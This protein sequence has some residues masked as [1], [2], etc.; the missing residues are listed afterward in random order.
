M[1]TK[2]EERAALEKIV[3]IIGGLGVDSYIGAAIDK[4]VLDIAEDNITNDWLITTTS[5][6]ESAR[7][8]AEDFKASYW[9]EHN[10][11]EN[12]SKLEEM[13][14]KNKEKIGELQETIYKMQNQKLESDNEKID[15]NNQIRSLEKV[16]T[17]LKAKLYDL[18][19][20]DNTKNL[21]KE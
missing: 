15:L 8:E 1:V 9:S 14:D 6:I 17:E 18:L 10:E 13:L 3:T 4:T 21:G 16:I 20:T 11:L 2:D 12:N 5:K 7:K 19:F